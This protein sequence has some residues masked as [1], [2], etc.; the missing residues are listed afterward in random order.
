MTSLVNVEGRHLSGPESWLAFLL[1][2]SRSPLDTSLR[3]PL[4]PVVAFLQER[5]G[6]TPPLRASI[7]QE[8]SVLSSFSVARSISGQ[9][10]ASLLRSA[11]EALPHTPESSIMLV[12]D[13]GSENVNVSVSD[14]LASVQLKLHIAQVDVSF[15]N[16]MIEA[17]NKIRNRQLNRTRVNK[18]I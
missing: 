4:A 5:N 18:I 7:L 6:L 2:I 10:T 1:F 14:Y 8:Q 11:M 9:A 3:V 17:V 16:S 12:S 15:S 13:G